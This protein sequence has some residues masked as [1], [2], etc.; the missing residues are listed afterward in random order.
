MIDNKILP[1]QHLELLVDEMKVLKEEGDEA[2]LC[3][4]FNNGC[5]VQKNKI[6]FRGFS[7][8]CKIKKF[9]DKFG[10]NYNKLLQNKD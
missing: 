2:E 1:N 5:S 3:E 8:H 4:Y 9:Y 7:K 6:C 10:I